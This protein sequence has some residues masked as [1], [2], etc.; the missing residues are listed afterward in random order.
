[1]GAPYLQVHCAAVLPFVCVHS[2]ASCWGVIQ[3]LCAARNRASQQVKANQPRGS[4][5]WL[6]LHDNLK[7]AASYVYAT[8]NTTS[9]RGLHMH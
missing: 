4:H 5:S 9:Q 1:M 3:M 6:Q 2:D 7:C 8:D